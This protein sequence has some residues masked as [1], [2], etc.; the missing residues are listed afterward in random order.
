MTEYTEGELS[1]V[2]RL[3]NAPTNQRNFSPS[4]VTVQYRVPIEQY[5]EA[6]KTRPFEAYIDYEAIRNNTS[7]I[8]TPEIRFIDSELAID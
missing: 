7:G 2:L 1:L 3:E 4:T 6:E 8:V 5:G